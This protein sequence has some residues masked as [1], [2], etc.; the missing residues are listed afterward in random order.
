ML[1]WFG[2]IRVQV[3]RL[4]RSTEVQTYNLHDSMSFSVMQSTVPRKWV[5]VLAIIIVTYENISLQRSRCSPFLGSIEAS[6]HMSSSSETPW[7]TTKCGFEGCSNV[8]TVTR[9]R[10]VPPRC[11]TCC[12]CGMHRPPR[13]GADGIFARRGTRNPEKVLVRDA[14]DEHYKFLSHMEKVIDNKFWYWNGCEQQAGNT[15]FTTFWEKHGLDT[16]FKKW[17][18]VWPWQQP[19]ECRQVTSSTPPGRPRL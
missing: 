12:D 13:K 1:R 8:A 4:A 18:S 9:C 2:Y 17:V 5:P 11:G 19:V 16:H 15:T 3:C 7:N 14:I 10:R 6:A